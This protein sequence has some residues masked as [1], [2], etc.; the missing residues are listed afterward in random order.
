MCVCELVG[1]SG[2]SCSVR[3]FSGGTYGVGGSSP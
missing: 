2:P 3:D 1:R